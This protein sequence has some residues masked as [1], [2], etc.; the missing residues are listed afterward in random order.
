MSFFDVAASVSAPHTALI[1][2]HG[3]AVDRR[4]WTPQLDAFPER[5]VIAPDARGHG[6]SSDADSPYRLAD[7]V[8][9]VMDALEIDRAVLAGVSMGGGTAVDVAL[10]H[11]D[12]CAALVVT[13]TGTSEPVFT[14]PWTLAAFREWKDAVAAG[15]VDAWVD[16]FMRFTHGPYRT[17]AD[18]DPTV[19]A[20]VEQMARETLLG[21]LRCD[22]GGAPVPPTPP[23][24]VP[25]TWGRVPGIGVPVLALS[26]ALDAPDHLE[27]GRRLA[28]LAP[29]GAHLEIPRAAHYPN[30]EQ[31]AE[32][33]RTV[34][35]FLRVHR[36]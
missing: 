1:L 19:D 23:S 11:P 14:D 16:V 36:L 3:G 31:P 29:A 10:E 22:P 35:E 27:N 4:M 33:A 17:R 6:G 5:R 21:H 30:L 32:Y 8:V 12:R 28:E 13:G 25:G 15:D 18:L 34:Q 24:P 2:L 7:D 9:A 26:G 20:L